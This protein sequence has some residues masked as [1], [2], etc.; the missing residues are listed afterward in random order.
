MNDAT[1][2]S[3]VTA[4]YERLAA[5][6]SSERNAR[7]ANRI[8]DRLHRA[9]LQLRETEEGRMFVESLLHH[10]DRGVRLTAAAD[11]LAWGSASAISALEGLVTPRGLHSLDAEMT[12]R[13]YH[14]GRMRFDW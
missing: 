2:G 6:W 11:C 10:E 3:D 8:F 12:L 9:A 5:E 1:Q 14:A 7:K 4:E 13:E